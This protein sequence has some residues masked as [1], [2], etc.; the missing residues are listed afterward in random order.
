MLNLLQ[1]ISSLIF[2]FHKVIATA[3]LILAILSSILIFRIDIKTDIMD[4]LPAE[5]P[6]VNTF[7]NFIDDFGSMSNLIIVLKSTDK[8]VEE[9]IGLAEYIGKR[10]EKSPF[11]EYADY[12]ILNLNKGITA[13]NF[14]LF[15]NREAL[16]KLKEDLQRKA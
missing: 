6:V 2:R 1:T 10:L 13:G 15:L 12:N 14:P 9:Y 5:N 7:I 16:E 8:K 4:A 3:S 11:I